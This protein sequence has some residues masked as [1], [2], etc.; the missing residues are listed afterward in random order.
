[1]EREKNVTRTR[2]WQR[3]HR[4]EGSGV[5][6][7]EKKKRRETKLESG[8]DSKKTDG[9]AMSTGKQYEERC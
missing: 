9:L 3:S 1:M 7:G 5:R 6:G 2:V 8:E 4:A